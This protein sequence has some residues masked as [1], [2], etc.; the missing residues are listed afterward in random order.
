MCL[1]MTDRCADGDE[2]EVR[3]GALRTRLPP[4]D[5]KILVPRG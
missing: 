2:A 4:R 1:V 3:D 5:V